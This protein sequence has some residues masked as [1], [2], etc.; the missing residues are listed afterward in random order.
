[1]TSCPEGCLLAST[2]DE[3]LDRFS[4]PPFQDLVET[5]WVVGGVGIYREAMSHPR[6]FRIYLTQID[7]EISC[8]TF[9]PSFDESHFEIVTDEKAPQGLQSTTASSGNAAS[10]KGRR[11]NAKLIDE[12]RCV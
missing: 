12:R 3:A 6:C 2:I 1:M 10:G 7:A 9:F 8:D 11:R 5:V 4:Q